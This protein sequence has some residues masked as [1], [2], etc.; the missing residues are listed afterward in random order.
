MRILIVDDEKE[1]LE[2]LQIS[3][4]NEFIVDITD[5]PEEARSY[6]DAY[7]YGVVIFDRTFY[8]VDR[9]KELIQYSKQKNPQMAVL[10]LSALSN[11]DDKVEGFAYG[12]DDYLEKPFDIKEL[13]ARIKALSRRFRQKKINIESLT[14]DIENKTIECNGNILKLSRNEHNLF[15]YLLIRSPNIVSR[16][17]ILDAIYDHPESLIS[18]VIDELVARLRKKIHTDIIKTIKTRGYVI[19]LPSA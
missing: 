12:A 10:V 19:E 16:E 17:E 1:L 13:R 2:L 6:L 4:S 7:S 3:L 8:G 14:I 9:V 11:V 18:N 15:F 5:T